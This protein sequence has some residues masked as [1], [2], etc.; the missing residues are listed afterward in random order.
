MNP[1]VFNQ[2]VEQLNAN[3]NRECSIKVLGA[4]G[5]VLNGMFLGV[6]QCEPKELT[7][8]A[9]FITDVPIYKICMM[10]QEPDRIVPVWVNSLLI[11]EIGDIKFEWH[12][13]ENLN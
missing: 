10:A 9:G 1:I 5:F 13:N 4:N 2:Y 12:C 7:D 6:S 8:M 3:K 11:E